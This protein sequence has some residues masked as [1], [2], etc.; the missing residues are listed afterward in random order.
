MRDE[1]IYNFES[2]VEIDFFLISG[3]VIEAREIV[4]IPRFHRPT[5]LNHIRKVRF[6]GLKKRIYDT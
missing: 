2:K 6:D 3:V 5:D 1:N 4:N